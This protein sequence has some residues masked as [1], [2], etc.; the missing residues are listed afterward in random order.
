M[1][2]SYFFVLALLTG[3]AT[4][5]PIYKPVTVEVPVVKPC[6]IERPAAPTSAL[7]SVDPHASLF[8]KTKAMLIELDHRMAYEAWLESALQSCP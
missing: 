8:D 7:A 3:C 5:E 1:N 2:K 6:V 4:P